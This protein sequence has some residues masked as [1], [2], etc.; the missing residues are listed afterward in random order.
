VLRRVLDAPE[1]DLENS[2]EPVTARI[3]RRDLEPPPR[4]FEADILVARL[5]RNA[6]RPL[7]ERRIFGEP[8][9]SK[10]MCRGLLEALGL[11]CELASQCAR[12]DLDP[13]ALCLDGRAGAAD[14]AG[15]E[16]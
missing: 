12:V 7:G 15:D 2:G 3:L 14:D 10:E 8:R 5:V 4:G 1:A 11:E 16:R 13:V 9:G 6:R